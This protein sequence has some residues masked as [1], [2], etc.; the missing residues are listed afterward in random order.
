MLQTLKEVNDKRKKELQDGEA[1][2]VELDKQY[3]E[4]EMKMRAMTYS[5]DKYQTLADELKAKNEE[6]AKSIEFHIHHEVCQNIVVS[7]GHSVNATCVPVPG[8]INDGQ[9]SN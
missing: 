6:L 2:H 7:G 5:L 9:R 3:V 1:K 8:R 4:M